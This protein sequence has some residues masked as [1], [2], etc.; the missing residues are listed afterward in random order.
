MPP[1]TQRVHR[2]AR[3]GKAKQA[4]GQRETRHG[5]PNSTLMCRQHRLPH[6]VL[7]PSKHLGTGYGGSATTR[8]GRK[9][10]WIRTDKKGQSGPTSS[11]LIAGTGRSCR[12]KSCKVDLKEMKAL[13]TACCTVRFRLSSHNL[14]MELGRNQ[15]VVWLG[16]GRK[17]CAAL[18]MH[19]LPVDDEA[20]L[21]FT[22]PAA[23]VVRRERQFAQLPCTSL[24]DLMCCRD[25]CGVALFVHKCMKIADAA[26]I[27][28][29]RQQ[30]R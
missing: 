2:G 9:G 1:N 3:Q 21:P 23:T 13:E 26:A 14:G 17:R 20:H 29:A 4:Q 8:L 7:Q 16:R 18:G 11:Q 19:D 27:A 25:V 6:N 5:L 24:Q 22:C 12:V 15:G 30:P 10:T 28:A